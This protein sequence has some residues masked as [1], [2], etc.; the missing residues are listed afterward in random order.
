MVEGREGVERI[1]SISVQIHDDTICKG[2]MG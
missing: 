1:Q 2:V